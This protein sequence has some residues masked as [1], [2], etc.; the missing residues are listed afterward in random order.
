MGEPVRVADV[1]RR[2]IRLSGKE[3][4]R[5][6]EIRMI[7][8]RPGEKIIEELFDR[9][10]EQIAVDADGVLA[11]RSQPMRLAALRKG[12]AELE[13]LCIRQD[14]VAVRRALRHLVPGYQAG[15]EASQAA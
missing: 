14:E 6:I 8:L 12:I 15:I 10:E 13:T 5:D 11:A 2:M 4:G 3:P 1:A 9:Q 7:G